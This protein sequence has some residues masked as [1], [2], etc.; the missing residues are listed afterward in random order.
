MRYLLAA[1]AALA[2]WELF[3]YAALT[4]AKERLRRRTQRFAEAHGVRVDLFKFG[5]KQ[6]V[7]EELFNDLAVQRAMLAAAQAGER[8]EDVRRRVEEYVD[9]IVPAFSLSAYFEVGLKLAGAAVRSAYRPI[10]VKRAPD[11]PRDATAVFL[12][13]HRS[14]FD[15][16]VVG[17]ALAQ[18]VAISYAVGEWARIFPLDALFR[19]FGGFFVRRGFPDPLYHTVLRRYLQLITRHGVTQGIFPEGGLTRDGALRVP[20]VGL[21][22][23]LLQLALDPAFDRD[24]LFVPVGINYDRVLEDEALL[25]EQ[26]GR[27]HPPTAGEKLRGALR[28]LWIVPTRMFFNAFRA[29]TGRLRRSG[30]AAVAFGEPISVRALLAR[31]G[32][33][34]AASIALPD[35]ERRELAKDVARELMDRIAHCIPATP[36]PLVAR[37]MLE[38]R[39]APYSRIAERVRDLREELARASVP[40]ALGKEF[41][42]QLRGRESLEEERSSR[43][44]ASLEGEV[45]GLEEAEQLVRLGVVLLRRRQILRSAAGVVRIGTHPHAEELLEYYARSLVLLPDRTRANESQRALS[46]P[47]PPAPRPVSG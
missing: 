8:A 45:L 11:L 21:L 35:D 10:I 43:V 28:L 19:A 47:I 9:E 12:I 2:A 18:R 17:W 15:Y 38:L 44:V 36:V 22:D 4:A 16:V 7:R 29:A 23:G 41:E 25:A 42:P 39:E 30:Y 6:L 5:G 40:T 34:G 1:L 14:N 37:A 20:K 33:G 13:N 24:L 46:Q 31:R 26:R 3:R 27:E 32:H